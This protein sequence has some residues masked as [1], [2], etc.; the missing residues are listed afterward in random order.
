MLVSLAYVSI[1]CVLVSMQA[2]GYFT[3]TILWEGGFFRACFRFLHGLV[4]H[5]SHLKRRSGRN[6]PETVALLE[7]GG[8]G[9]A[10]TECV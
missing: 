8:R 3:L 1:M 5:H 2:V 10:V 7:E 6:G 9:R 4:S